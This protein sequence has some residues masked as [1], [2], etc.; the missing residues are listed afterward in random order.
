MPWTPFAELPF[1]RYAIP[2]RFTLYAFLAAAVIV[3]LWLAPAADDGPLGA[4]GRRRA[5]RSSPASAAARGHTH[6]SDP[7]FFVDGCDQGGTARPPTM[8]STIPA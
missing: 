3:A 4:G 5:R 2:L 7:P 1:L 6:L 8:C